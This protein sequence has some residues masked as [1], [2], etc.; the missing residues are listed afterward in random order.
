LGTNDSK[1]QNWQ[2][3]EEYPQDMQIMIDAF[4]T[5]PS[6]PNI[7]L[8]YPAKAYAKQWGINDSIIVNDVIPYIKQVAEKNNLRIIDLYAATENMEENFPDKI[9]PNKYGAIVL[10]ETVYKAIQR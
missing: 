4:R 5:L 8:C 10:A 6:H 7:Y 2:Y 3:K 1:P 9:H